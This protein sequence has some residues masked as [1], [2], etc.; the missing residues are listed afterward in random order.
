MSVSKIIKH[1]DAEEE[2]KTLISQSVN[3]INKINF[4]DRIYYIVSFNQIDK[5]ISLQ[6]HF[7]AVPSVDCLSL[8][9]ER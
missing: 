2:E 8:I 5:S 7:F 6:S 1:K 9:A 4:Y 3:L